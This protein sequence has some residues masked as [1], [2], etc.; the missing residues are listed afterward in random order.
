MVVSAGAALVMG[1]GLMTA[2]QGQTKLQMVMARAELKDGINAKKAKPGETIRAKLEGSVTLNDGHELPKGT[3]IEGHVD[4]AQA[5]EHKSDSSV[6]VTFDKAQLKG[7]EELPIKAT[8]VSIWEPVATNAT[9]EGMPPSAMA[10]QPS[11]PSGKGSAPPPAE[12]IHDPQNASQQ[13]PEG[14]PRKSVPGVTLHSD[15]HEKS[16]ATLT[17]NKKNVDVP[18]G[19]QMEFEVVV[20]PAGVQIQ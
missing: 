8:L 19:T 11:G 4:Q 13:G 1:S 12:S 20:I 7:G 17:A 10:G 6:V 14:S 3:I 9:A 2:A 16:S 5:S 18:D 15:I